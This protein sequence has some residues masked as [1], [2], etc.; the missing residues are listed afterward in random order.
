MRPF[1]DELGLS[2]IT[3][4]ILVSFALD[5]LGLAAAFVMPGGVWVC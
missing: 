1:N 5:V 2:L 4:G 3:W